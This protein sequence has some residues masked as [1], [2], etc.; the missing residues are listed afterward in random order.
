M[1]AGSVLR[2]V[3]GTGAV[4]LLAAMVVLAGSRLDQR[5]A[6]VPEASEVVYLPDARV[7][8]PLA[9]GWH[10]VLADVLWFRTINYFGAHYQADRVYP[11]LAQMCEIVTDLDPRAEHVYLFAGLILPWEAHDVDGGLRLLEKGLRTFPDDWQLHYQLGIVHYLFKQDDA[12]AADHLGQAARLPGAPPIVARVAALLHARQ[13][14]PE[15][16]LAFLRQMREQATSREMRE[17]I[18]R[19]IQEAQLAWDVQRLDALVQQYRARTGVL[20][21]S[22]DVLVQAGL[23]RGVPGDPFGG[24]YVV[25]RESGAVRSSTGYVPLQMH[26]SPRRRDAEKEAAGAAAGAH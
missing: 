16:T 2:S 12:T 24:T 26:D 3:A 4:A 6:H 15:T 19:N 10:T 14:G 18:D 22:L 11:W 5:P 7:L 8:R 25:D 17:V 23:L 21:D 9:L 20:P 13:H 1:H